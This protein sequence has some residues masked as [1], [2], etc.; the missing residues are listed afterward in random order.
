MTSFRPIDLVREHTS[1]SGKLIQDVT[2]RAYVLREGM[3]AR[4]RTIDGP[5]IIPGFGLAALSSVAQLQ[6]VQRQVSSTPTEP[7]LALTAPAAL[8]LTA[9]YQG[10][11]DGGQ[12]P[13]DLRPIVTLEG[14]D[15]ASSDDISYSAV[16]SGVTGTLDNAG[17]SPTKGTVTVTDLP[18][19]TGTIVWTLTYKGV[20]QPTLTASVVKQNAAPPVVVPAP[21]VFVPYTGQLTDLPGVGTPT[22]ITERIPVLVTASGQTITASAPT[23]YNVLQS[24]KARIADVAAQW[25][26][27]VVGTT[28]WTDF[29]PLIQGSEAVA[30]NEQFNDY[31]PTFE[32]ATEGFGAFIQSVTL[33][34]GSYEVALFAVRTG[35]AITL[36][37]NVTVERS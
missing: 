2:D 13:E 36:F 5:T 16:L 14:G 26:W 27:R 7:T 37:S 18:G 29:G 3:F 23:Y 9:D 25:R 19:S 24:Y 4:S 15:A 28:V 11:L 1:P 31:E 12:L 30:P 33:P 32:P 21:G 35:A 10:V 6:A 34:A 20:V 8:V 22:Q 17:A